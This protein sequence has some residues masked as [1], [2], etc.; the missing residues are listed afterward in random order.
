MNH[1]VFICRVNPP[2]S[3][4]ALVMTPEGPGWQSVTTWPQVEKSDWCAK[5]EPQLN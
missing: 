1:A 2:V 3:S 5:F 4:A